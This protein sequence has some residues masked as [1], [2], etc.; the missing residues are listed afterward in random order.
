[1]TSAEQ[2]N[3]K[4]PN[5]NQPRFWERVHRSVVVIEPWG[6]LVAVVALVLTVA[7]FWIDYQDRVG[8]R[9]VRAWTANAMNW[10]FSVTDG[11]NPAPC[12]PGDRRTQGL[13]RRRAP[14]DS[15]RTE[16]RG[17]RPCRRYSRASVAEE[18]Q[19]RRGRRGIWAG[20]FQRPGDWRRQN[21][22]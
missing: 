14:A 5:G 1:M 11:R 19:A 17:T 9:V 3:N 12:Q 2:P 20:S 7:Q 4:P 10:K 16:L 6:I 8:E 15:V 18:D 21:R 22:L 13:P